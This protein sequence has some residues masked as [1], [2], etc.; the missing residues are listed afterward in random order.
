MSLINKANI[1]KRIL[2]SIFLKEMPNYAIVYIDG[3][4]NM[5]CGFCF[6]AAVNARKTPIMSAENW[7]NVFKRAKSLLHVT[8]TGGE[9]FLRKDFVEIISNI[10][11]SSGVPRVS[12]NS[13]GFYKDRIIKF[14]PIL[15]KK[16]KNT[17]FTLSISIDGPEVI[18]DKVRVFK[19]A[20]KTALETLELINP[21]RKYENFF[22]KLSSVLTRDNMSFM[23]SFLDTTAGWDIDFHELIL[24]RDVPVEEQLAVK[25]EFE[26]LNKVQHQRASKSFKRSFNGK[27]FKKLYIETLKKVDNDKVFS[28]CL[29][30]GR[31]V[32]IFPDGVVRGCEIEKLWDVSKIGTVNENNLDIVD[33]INSHK[34]KE[35]QKIAKKCTCTFECASAINTVYDPKHW[36]SLI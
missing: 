20:Y 6:H 26:K 18:H 8:I 7:G 4:C 34:A 31:F 14:L 24:V 12:I 36:V 25:D 2:K 17:E 11:E 19:G 3:R 15:I 13:N 16:F 9:P 23:S 5:N 33:V 27:L 1:A 30:G 21:Y 29:A 10:I 35:F 22:L 32:E 28:P